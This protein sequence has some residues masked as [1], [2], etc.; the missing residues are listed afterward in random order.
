MVF[1][2][3]TS[4]DKCPLIFVDDGVKINQQIYLEDVLKKHVQPCIKA[5]FET[6]PYVFQQ[7]SAPAHKAKTVQQWCQNNLYD[8]ISSSQWPPNSPD[9]NPL[10]YSVWAVLEKKACSTP[11]KSLDSLKAALKKA[12]AELDDDYLR[13]AVDSFP[14]RL[15]LCVRAKGGRIEFDC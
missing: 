10:D 8:F 5:H 15:R 4:D 7:D 6:R 12:W 9:I 13:A 11:H 1:G 3:I 2:C 14:R